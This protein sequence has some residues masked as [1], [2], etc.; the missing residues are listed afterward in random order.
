MKEIFKKN[1][2]TSNE[3]FYIFNEVKDKENLVE[4]EIIKVALI[5]QFVLDIEENKFENCESI[6]DYVMSENID[7]EHSVKNYKTI[8]EILKKDSIITKNMAINFVDGFI[9]ELSKN[10][11]NINIGDIISK[12]EDINK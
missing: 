3:I 4:Q 5:A 2:L 1:Y 12:L 9:N 7:L 10:I 11:E 6:Y 8:D